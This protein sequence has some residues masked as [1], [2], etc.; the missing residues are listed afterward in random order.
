MA[1]KLTNFGVD[2][3]SSFQGAKNGVTFGIVVKTFQ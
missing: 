2:G 3:V 1:S